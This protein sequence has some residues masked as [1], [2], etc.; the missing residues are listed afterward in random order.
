MQ[1]H[2]SKAAWQRFI[3]TS[4]HNMECAQNLCCENTDIFR[5][6]ISVRGSVPLW[7][8]IRVYVWGQVIRLVHICVFGGVRGVTH[9]E[10]SKNP[11]IFWLCLFFQMDDNDSNSDSTS[12]T[13]TLNSVAESGK[14]P[15][16]ET[17]MPDAAENDGTENLTATRKDSVNAQNLS[18]EVKKVRI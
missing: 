3:E 18:D 5:L 8:S 12:S 16:G 1:E 10:T 17:Q 14:L 9:L 2:S 11:F 6:G 15:D 13:L 4:A 7:I